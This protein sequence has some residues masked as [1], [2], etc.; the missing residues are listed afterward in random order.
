LKI[1]VSP[2]EERENYWIGDI[3]ILSPET[4]GG[5]RRSP[6]NPTRNRIGG[7][8]EGKRKRLQYM[9][10][11]KEGLGSPRNAPQ[12]SSPFLE[13]RRNSFA[14]Q[15]EERRKKTKE[16]ERGGLICPTRNMTPIFSSGWKVSESSNED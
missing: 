12:K 14:N 1:T 13:K 2:R 16:E 7:G 9:K 3:N 10:E 11:L 6:P 15:S 8:R 4:D 5:K